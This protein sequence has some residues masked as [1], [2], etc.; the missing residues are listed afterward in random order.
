MDDP[1]RT[2]QPEE[3]T[4]EVTALHLA[5]IGRHK[6]IVKELMQRTIRYPN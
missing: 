3:V 4:M 1:V 2:S 5:V 6:H